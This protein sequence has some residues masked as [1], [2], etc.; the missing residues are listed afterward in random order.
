MPRQL[1]VYFEDDLFKKIV[2]DSNKKT[3][4][5]GKRV[6]YTK[7]INDIIREYFKTKPVM[8]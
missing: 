3:E 1:I 2:H 4:E 5:A 8:N 7:I 6:S